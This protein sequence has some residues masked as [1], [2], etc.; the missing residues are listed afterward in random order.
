MKKN[1]QSVVLTWFVFFTTTSVAFA[2]EAGNYSG[3]DKLG[4]GILNA[5]TCPVEIPRAIALT[6]ESNGPA[7]GWTV[8]LIEGVGRTLIR[9]GMGLVEVVTFPFDFPKGDKGPLIRPEFAWQEW[10]KV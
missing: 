3:T 2:A 7:Y 8:G 9:F 10:E 1:C 5:V 4:R 6:S